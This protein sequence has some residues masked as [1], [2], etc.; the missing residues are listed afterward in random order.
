VTG[1]EVY[2]DL[3]DVI[4]IHGRI[5]GVSSTVAWD[6]LPDPGVLESAPSCWKLHASIALSR[7]W[8]REHDRMGQGCNGSDGALLELERSLVTFVVKVDAMRRAQR[9]IGRKDAT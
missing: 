9:R 6:Q 1:D 8:P 5:F 4:R 2:L 3:D 7:V